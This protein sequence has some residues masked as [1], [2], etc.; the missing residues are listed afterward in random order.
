MEASPDFVDL[1]KNFN[2]HGVRYVVVG[3]YALAHHGHPRYT[4]DLDVLVAT[5]EANA[6]RVVRALAHFGFSG[7]D[8]AR[9]D[10][11]EPGF[12]VRL[13]RP[14][15]QIDLLTKLEGVEWENIEANRSDGS[16]GEVPVPFIG[17]AQL[18]QAKRSSGRTQDQADIEALG[19]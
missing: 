18:I 2:A 14:P 11:V 17:R 15:G 10:F 9:S 12:V 6:D 7:P 8:I 4:G 16:I 3:A 1:L 19:E 5:G 13:G